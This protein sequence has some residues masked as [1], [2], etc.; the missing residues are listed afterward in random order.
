[1][2]CVFIRVIYFY[3]LFLFLFLY[4]FIYILLSYYTYIVV[5]E[6]GGT[7]EELENRGT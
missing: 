4:C 6:L 2:I 1:M 7:I 3:I 5:E